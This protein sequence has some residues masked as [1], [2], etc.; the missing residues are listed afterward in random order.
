[1]EKSKNVADAE[2]QELGDET[3]MSADD[4]RAYMRQTAMAKASK[5]VDAMD[6][7]ANAREVL[8]K[9][10]SE[11]MKLTPDIVADIT[12]R[13]LSKLRVAA[14]QGN[15]ELMVMRFPSALCTDSGRAINNY[16]AGWP[17]T[18]IGRPR[19]A[20]ELWRDKLQPA[21]FRL[22]AMIVD[23]PEGLPGDV[24]FFLEWGEKKKY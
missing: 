13:L 16:E 21:G 8:I 20:Y 22:R 6:R 12:K 11:P 15:T 3:F 18:L 7:A 19:Q 9:T 24:G 1:M 23:W 2:A 17:E 10:L 5:D 4:L 14:G